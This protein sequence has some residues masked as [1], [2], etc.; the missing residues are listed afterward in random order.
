MSLGKIRMSKV[1]FILIIVAFFAISAVIFNQI[2]L[3]STMVVDEEF[4]LP[5]GI[6]YCKFN[7]FVWDPKVTTLPGLYLV[8]ALFMGPL[9]LCTIYWMRFVSLV[10]SIFNIILF[11]KLFRKYERNEW[12]NILS[13]ITLALL[14]PLYFFSNFYYTDVV[15]MTMILSMIIANEKKHHYLAAIFGL[16]SVI[17]RQTNVV[18]V[19][20]IAAR[21]ILTELYSF[22][23]L[24]QQE[25]G[26]P[27][28][29]LFTFFRRVIKR[30]LKVL[31]NSNIQF[32]LDTLSYLATLGTFVLFIKING[33]IV[34]GDKSAHEATIHIPQLFY[35]SI[36]C[37]VFAWPHFVGEVL[38]FITFTKRNKLLIFIL[39][40]ICFLIVYANTLVH[41]Y[42]LADNR[43]YIFYIWNRFYGKYA[44]FKY[45]IIPVYIF[46]WYV[47][48][49]SLY[50]KHDISFLALYL[51]CT[52]AVLITQKLIEVRYFFI[53]YILF[54]L[55]IKTNTNSVFNI[56]LEFVTYLVVNSITLNLFFT[57]TIIWPEYEDP[58]RLIW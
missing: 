6:S 48:I 50:S 20:L 18:W 7:F 53:P 4:H 32:W 1:C 19:G 24:R 35:F 52:T 49:K 42:M 40:I 56:V 37:L 11:Y 25:K 51:L 43:H 45:T 41:P 15:S 23:K 29:D 55:R 58:Q 3:T 46:A 44:L 39:I 5:L 14:P 16:F 12:G 47:I 31:E 2:Y 8:S 26:V 28:K 13:S 10:C 22:T 30:P 9:K 21:Y 54:R 36:F 57:K 34:V 38:N 17:C 33:S 27:A